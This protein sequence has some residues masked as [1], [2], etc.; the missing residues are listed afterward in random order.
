[1]AASNCCQT[2]FTSCALQAHAAMLVR[3]MLPAA[4]I[5]AQIMHC[6]VQ[7]AGVRHAFNNG[8]FQGC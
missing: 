4:T 6:T 1:M 2:K 3:T 5:L 7:P 8:L